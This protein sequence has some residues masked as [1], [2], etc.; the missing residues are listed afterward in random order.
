[1]NAKQTIFTLTITVT[2]GLIGW[3]FLFA[4]PKALT[5]IDY[6]HWVENPDNGLKQVKNI[7]NLRFSLQYK[8]VEYVIANEEKS[9]SLD[10]VLVHNRK[11]Q[12]DGMQY[13]NLRYSLNNSQQNIVKAA[14]SIEAQ[15]QLI[16]YL[17]YSL[18]QDIRLVEGN[19]TLPC[20]LFHFARNHGLTPHA[21]FVIGFESK[22]EAADKRLIIN[23]KAFNTGTVQFN[24]AS[25]DLNDVPKLLTN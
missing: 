24:I 21:D 15:Q 18:Q 14:G 11:E 25:A 5:P 12:L 19:D 10:A 9:A 22:N 6:V 3:M 17:S 8:P 23:E 7:G 16:Y 1:M 4:S 20:Q 13:F 2:I